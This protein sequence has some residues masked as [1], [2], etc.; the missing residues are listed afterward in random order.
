MGK[1]IDEQNLAG[2]NDVQGSQG[3][4]KTDDLSQLDTVAEESATDEN[5]NASPS[6]EGPKEEPAKEEPQKPKIGGK[7]DDVRKRIAEKQRTDREKAK[8]ESDG[9]VPSGAES[10]YFGGVATGEVV[11][12]PADE[13]G[14]EGDK[15]KSGEMTAEERAA[16]EAKLD[17]NVSGDQDPMVTL[18]VNGMVVQKPLS[19][20][21]ALAQQQM[22]TPDKY[23][24]LAQ[25]Q[26]LLDDQLKLLRQAKEDQP[27]AGK[28][29]P[30][31]EDTRQYTNAELDSVIEDMQFGN[32]DEAKA[33]FEKYGENL[34]GQALTRIQEQS[35][36]IEQRVREVLQDQE[37]QRENA[38]AAESFAERHPNL[39][40]T[41]SGQ[42]AVVA[43]SHAV[44]YES[45]KGVGYSSNDVQAFAQRNSLEIPQALQA[46]YRHANQSGLDVPTRDE[47]LER[48]AERVYQHLGGQP[49]PSPENGNADIP[50]P[51][52]QNRLE[53][54][55]AAANAQP[56]RSGV[57][58]SPQGGAVSPD[59]SRANAVRQRVAT[60]RR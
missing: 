44:L 31:K 59:I 60:A 19:E 15:S 12:E 9:I 28:T 7:G 30:G 47:V 11:D 6:A 41:P 38:R 34:I 33:A 4:Q 18:K 58:G 50:K 51:A 52:S 24:K 46:L 53:R 26:Q 39:S 2:L 8:S 40:Q 45:L 10:L 13:G 17:R 36:N 16:A 5:D 48:A 35:G 27:D 32:A 14:D 49:N 23:E 29:E 55:R 21:Q 56:R 57:P 20:V 3:G 54:K 25:R 37:Y 22:A 43:E 1:E 42:L